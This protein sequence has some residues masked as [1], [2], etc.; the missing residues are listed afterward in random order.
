MHR[1]IKAVS[2]LISSLL[3][4]DICHVCLSC[5]FSLLQVH[6]PVCY[7]LLYQKLRQEEEE[8][9]QKRREREL[10]D[11]EKKAEM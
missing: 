2:Y 7:K 1:C 6:D 8:A 11:R 4:W 9:A 3:Y 10:V 5:H